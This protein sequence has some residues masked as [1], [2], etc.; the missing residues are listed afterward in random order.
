MIDDPKISSG[1]AYGGLVAAPIFS[2]I[3]ERAARHLDL[4]PSLRAQPVA[5][6]ALGTPAKERVN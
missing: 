5:P 4:V 2:R 6:L 3:G 1:L